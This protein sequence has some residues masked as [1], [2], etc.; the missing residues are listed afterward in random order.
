ME[1]TEQVVMVTV[2]TLWRAPDTQDNPLLASLETQHKASTG[3]RQVKHHR[4]NTWREFA[5]LTGVL[6]KPAVVVGAWMTVSASVFLQQLQRGMLMR[7][8]Q[9]GPVMQGSPTLIRMLVRTTRGL[10]MKS[11]SPT[12]VLIGHMEQMIQS[13]M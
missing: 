13:T 6:S 3:R 10:V 7:V 2:E 1:K 5:M 9:L 8:T 12:Q 11:L 4:K